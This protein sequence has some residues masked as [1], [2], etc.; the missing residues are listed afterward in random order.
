MKIKLWGSVE[1]YGRSLLCFL[2][3]R[4]LRTHNNPLAT[5]CYTVLSVW[6]L[7]NY[8]RSVSYIGCSLGYPA[9]RKWMAEMKY[10]W[11]YC[12]RV[13]LCHASYIGET[14]NSTPSVLKMNTDHESPMMSDV[15]VHARSSAYAS[16]SSLQVHGCICS[17]LPSIWFACSSFP[18]SS[19]SK[20]AVSTTHCYSVS[21]TMS[22]GSSSYK[23]VLSIRLHW[24]LEEHLDRSA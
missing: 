16:N 18:G 14:R 21:S 1:Q 8:C 22:I 6:D 2:L 11:N 3:L 10:L 19:S 20:D 17:P 9:V 12:R 23:I 24:V 5:V 13:Y 7:Y 15:G 4:R